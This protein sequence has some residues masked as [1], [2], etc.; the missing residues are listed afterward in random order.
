MTGKILIV[1]DEPIIALD[2]E[3][4]L[5]DF[6]FEV[7]GRAQCADEALMAVEESLPDLAL[8]D[9][10]ILGSLDGVE[11][12]RLLRDAYRIP[13]IFLTAHNDDQTV[14]RAALE[15]PYGFLTKPF[16]SRELKATI[17]VAMHKAKIDAGVCRENSESSSALN[18]MYEALLALSLEGDIRFMNTAAERLTGVA[19]EDAS[20]RHF[21][22]VLHFQNPDSPL[23][24][25]SV[26]RGL[27]G[28]IESFGL[29]LRQPGRGP[30]LVDLTI[31]PMIDEDG[32]QTGSILTVRKAEQ[33][34]RS[35][36]L[37]DPQNEIEMFEF[38]PVPMVQLDSSGHIVRVNNAMLRNVDV[39]E[40]KLV[41]RTLAGLSRD[42]DP[43]IS[44]K[45][46]YQLLQGACN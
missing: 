8:M 45:L 26:R 2:L 15:M 13:S 41:G 16:Q 10:H 18:G 1:E 34:L 37:Q 32:M 23:S 20:G 25:V 5:V 44:G 43:R 40:E 9:L 7:T 3:Q 42:P 46:M 31:S 28:P 6:G 12:A 4:Q 35:H 30:V 39:A 17:R 19:R 24:F 29:M 38:A 11:T 21:R 22:E 27:S 33:R 14:S 36:A